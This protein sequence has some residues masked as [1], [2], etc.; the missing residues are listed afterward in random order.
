MFVRTSRHQGRSFW[1][2][3]KT[4]KPEKSSIRDH[5]LQYDHPLKSR[6]FSIIGSINNH[7]DLRVL[8]SI[9]IHHFHPQMNDNQSAVPLHIVP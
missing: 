4:L 1:T 7:F 2:G 5:S 8:E 6:N 9:H 3:A